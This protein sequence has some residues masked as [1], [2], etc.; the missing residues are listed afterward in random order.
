MTPTG[1]ASQACWRLWPLVAAGRGFHGALH[2]A[3]RASGLP[4]GPL[5]G[6]HAV[7]LL[8]LLVGGVL[9]RA[10]PVKLR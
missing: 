7:P 2:A 9:L 5:V 8:A 3:R 6:V 4:Q 10:L 1:Y